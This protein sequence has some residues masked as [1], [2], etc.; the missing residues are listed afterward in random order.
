MSHQRAQERLQVWASEP[1][2]VF[3]PL[4]VLAGVL[5]VGL[6]P[7]YF[8]ELIPFYPGMNHTRLMAFGF[9][10]GFVLGFVGTALPRL[11]DAPGLKAWELGLLG[12]LF[13]A[14]CGFHV[15][16]A[17]VWGE[18]A[19][20]LCWLFILVC[21]GPRVV[22]GKD[23]PPPGFVLVLLGVLGALVGGGV[24]LY[25]HGNETSAE[26]L[27]WRQLLEFQG[28]TLLPLMGAGGFI[29]P[30]MLGLPERQSFPVMRH[31]SR[32][33]WRQFGIAAGAGGLVL[34]TF[35]IELQGRFVVAYQLRFWVV[36]GYLTWQVPW[37][38]ARPGSSVGNSLRFGLGCVGAGL[39]LVS[40]FPAWRVAFLHLS[41][42]IGFVLVA[43]MVGARVVFG[44]GDRLPA[45]DGK[46]RWIRWVLGLIVV[47]VTSRMIGDWI[48]K[49]MVSHYVYGAIFWSAA[50]VIWWWF[51]FVRRR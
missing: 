4:A 45:L 29:L 6:W 44:H 8:A 43:L 46:R 2:R 51:V 16:G 10:G 22:R 27:I 37:H 39:L 38:Q 35:W 11:L 47:A 21:F 9:F 7:L 18:G 42:G 30:R 50:V 19:M 24:S 26:W 40:C 32:E 15:C 3:F 49:I 14:L 33:W 41:L 36:V 48:P 17:T 28:F 25:E 12:S 34:L 13:L 20:V 1:F 23:L 5:G 31:P